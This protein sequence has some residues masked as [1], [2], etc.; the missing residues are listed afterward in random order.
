M[1]PT[2]AT[3]APAPRH[4]AAPIS[5]RRGVRRIGASILRVSGDTDFRLGRPH[6]RRQFP[7]RV[8]PVGGD[9]YRGSVRI[10]TWNINSIRSRASR[11]IDWLGR[12]DVD[13]LALQEIKCTE[14][15]FPFE[16][17]DEAGYEVRAARPQPVE[18]RR[19]REP[20][21]DRGCRRSASRA[22][23]DSSRARR[24]PTC[25]RRRARSARPSTASASGASTCPTGAGSTTRTTS[26]SSTG[27]RLSPPTCATGSPREPELPLALMGD[28]NIAPLDSDVGDPTFIPGS[29]DA[30]LP[31]RARGVRRARGGRAQRRRAPDPPGGVHLLGL[32]AAAL[33]PQRGHAHRLHPRIRRRSPTGSS[34]RAS[35]AT[36]AR[37]TP[38]ATTS[39]CWSSSTSA[40][41][42]MTIAR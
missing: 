17:F 11:V 39:R 22:C 38:R 10:A 25:R 21:A 41:P 33:P 35:T 26:T 34:T 30:H 28:F 1:N 14:A 3:S 37:A 24:V 20:S 12:E 5:S 32:Q 23:P 2:A 19:H 9:H 16:L 4:T 7:I 31:A 27:S 8:P 6:P 29:L 15:Q 42:T 40:S 18:R 13:V 36:S